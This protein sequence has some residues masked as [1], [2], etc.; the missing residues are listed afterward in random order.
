MRK[1]AV[2]IC[3]FVASAGCLTS[4]TLA[5]QRQNGAD[6]APPRAHMPPAKE[7]APTE[8]TP[9]QLD[10]LAILKARAE[11]RTGNLF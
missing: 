3:L 7:A 4:L 2:Q 6:L 8:D 5:Q 9:A 10:A 1:I 11:K